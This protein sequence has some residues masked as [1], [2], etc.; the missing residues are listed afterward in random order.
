MRS[1]AALVCQMWT[2]IKAYFNGCVTCILTKGTW[3]LLFK[4]FHR[5]HLNTL[6]LRRAGCGASVGGEKQAAFS[7][8]S[9][10][11]VELHLKNP[12]LAT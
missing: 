11:F 7:L 4:L 9:G 2:K 1:S 8:A 3:L 10:L 12:Y 5:F 6:W